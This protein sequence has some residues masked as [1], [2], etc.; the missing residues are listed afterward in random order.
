[1]SGRCFHAIG[2]DCRGLIRLEGL[3]FR[4]QGSEGLGFRV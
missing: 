3:E 2:S 4:V 1:M